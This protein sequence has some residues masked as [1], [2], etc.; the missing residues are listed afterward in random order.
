MNKN[1]AFK[2]RNHNH[3]K[4]TYLVKEGGKTIY[5]RQTTPRPQLDD[6]EGREKIERGGSKVE[7]FGLIVLRILI[8]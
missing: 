3:V 5:S 4:P 7:I 8:T 1:T 6:K 2:R